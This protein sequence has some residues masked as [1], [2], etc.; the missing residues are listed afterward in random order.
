MP[1]NL[2]LSSKTATRRA[3]IC[4]SI[5]WTGSSSSR[6]HIHIRRIAAI[7]ILAAIT[8]DILLQHKR[9]NMSAV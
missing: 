1:Y 8:T 2:P 9:H 4:F 7:A 3:I 6:Q 5:A